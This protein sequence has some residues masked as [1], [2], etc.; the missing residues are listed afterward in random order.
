MDETFNA[1]AN[2]LRYENKQ[3][4]LADLNFR[5]AQDR[6]ASADQR[7]R[8]ALAKLRKYVEEAAGTRLF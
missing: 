7:R 8:A 4:R 6:L 2:N 3:H 5:R 1:L